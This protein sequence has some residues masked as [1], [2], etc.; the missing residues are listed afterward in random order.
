MNGAGNFVSDSHAATPLRLFC[1]L[2]GEKTRGHEIDCRIP[3]D[4]V[5]C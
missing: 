5:A 1:V 4:S 2:D 3:Q